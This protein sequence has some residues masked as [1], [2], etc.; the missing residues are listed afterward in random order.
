MGDDYLEEL[1]KH[2][3]PAHIPAF[4]G[5]GCK[6]E[7]ALARSQSTNSKTERSQPVSGAVRGT[8]RDKV[9]GAVRGAVE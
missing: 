9:R 3:D 7:G 4:L 5:G 2:I 6:C 8:V 1:E